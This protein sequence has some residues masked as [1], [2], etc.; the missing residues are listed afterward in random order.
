MSSN[1]H[2]FTWNCIDL[3]GILIIR[4]EPIYIDKQT[5]LHRLHHFFPT[6]T[7][8]SFPFISFQFPSRIEKNDEIDVK[9]SETADNK[10]Q[11]GFTNSVKGFKN[12]C[13]FQ[14]RR[15]LLDWVKPPKLTRKTPPY[16]PN[17]PKTTP[18]VENIPG[19]CYIYGVKG[20]IRSRSWGLGF[21]SDNYSYVDL[22]TPE[23]RIS[24]GFCFCPIS[25]PIIGFISR[26]SL[27]KMGKMCLKFIKNS[28]F[29]DFSV[30]TEIVQ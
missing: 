11:S 30:N 27:L 2:R 22:K 7:P 15:L 28:S 18:K 20:A 9:S 19:I 29:G 8:S 12:R 14:Y 25:L 4:I 24:S 5:I 10:E 26:F 16:P 6:L 23:T 17:M 1:L 3:H 21:T 13:K